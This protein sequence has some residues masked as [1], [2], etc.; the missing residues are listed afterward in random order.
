MKANLDTLKAEM[1][2]YIEESGLAVFHGYSRALDSMPTVYWDVARYPDFKMFVKTA[3]DS[4]AKLIVL[5]QREFD[6]AQVDDGLEQL[7]ECGLTE[8]EQSEFERRLG[9]MRV[10][11]GFIC[12]IELSF[13]H[14]GRVFVFDLRTDWYNELT[15]ILDEIQLLTADADDDDE[16]PMSGYF[17]KN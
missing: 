4:G 3:Q 6:S 17:S 16:T 7:S 13:D 10:Y 12:G 9:A 15:D 14:E 1:E 2:H 8:D 11:D 5:H